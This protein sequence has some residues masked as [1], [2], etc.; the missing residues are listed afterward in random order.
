MTDRGSKTRDILTDSRANVSGT[1]SRGRRR[2]RTEG[3]LQR[4]ELRNVRKERV[5][6]HSLEDSREGYVKR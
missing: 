1:C 5:K 4:K 6:K 2:V 3:M